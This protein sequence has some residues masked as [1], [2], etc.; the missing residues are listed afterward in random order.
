MVGKGG[1]CRGVEKGRPSVK[2]RAREVPLRF[3]SDNKH[4]R[5]QS[6]EVW[7]NVRVDRLP[8]Q[9]AENSVHSEAFK[10]RLNRKVLSMF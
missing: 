9:A 7:E 8:D 1:E 3:A 6:V 10:I 5:D 4:R 2:N